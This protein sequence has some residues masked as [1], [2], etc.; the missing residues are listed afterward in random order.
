MC[1]SEFRAFFS[2]AYS[3]GAETWRHFSD[4]LFAPSVPRAL[5]SNAWN[6]KML[7]KHL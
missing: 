4:K 5:F 3:G 6:V 7:G 2:K 1:I